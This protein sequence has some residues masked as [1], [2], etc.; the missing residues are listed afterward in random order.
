MWP[1]APAIQLLLRCNVPV[2]FNEKQQRSNPYYLF[3]KMAEEYEES[4][5]FTSSIRINP[6]TKTWIL[7]AW[8]RIGGFQK[9]AG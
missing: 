6:R 3:V 2:Q 5:M 9:E 7:S 1:G 4:T 8:A